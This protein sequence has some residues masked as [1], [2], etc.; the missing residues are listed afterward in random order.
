MKIYIVMQ[1]ELL[2]FG[3]PAGSKRIRRCFLSRKGA[4][5]HIGPIEEKYIK[6]K[7]CG[8]EHRNPAADLDNDFEPWRKKLSIEELTVYD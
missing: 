8:N 2:K 5:E 6:C 7:T 4:E 3:K 1:S